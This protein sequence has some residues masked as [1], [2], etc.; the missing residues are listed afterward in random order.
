MVREEAD[1]KARIEAEFRAKAEVD[2]RKKIEEELRAEEE[3]RERETVASASKT[4]SDRSLLGS[5]KASTANGVSGVRGRNGMGSSGRLPLASPGGSSDGT[6]VGSLS[7]SSDG[8]GAPPFTEGRML[9]ELEAEEMCSAITQI[10]L[11]SDSRSG[12]NSPFVL[13][14]VVLKTNRRRWTIERRYS[15]FV[16]LHEVKMREGS[17]VRSSRTQFNIAMC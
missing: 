1:M 8:W 17:A 7:R 12:S 2:A 16:W 3:Q 11:K 13:F 10:F 5:S 4:D 9:D 15:D 14:N 6:D